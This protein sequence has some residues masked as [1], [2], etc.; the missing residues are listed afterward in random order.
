MILK[1]L[2]VSHLLNFILGKLSVPNAMQYLLFCA[3]LQILSDQYQL[4]D[5]LEQSDQAMAV[6]KDLFGDAPR[7]HTGKSSP[8]YKSLFK[9]TTLAL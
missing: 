5:V 4:Q 3:S 1:S 9:I 6:V 8:L 2:F 7:R